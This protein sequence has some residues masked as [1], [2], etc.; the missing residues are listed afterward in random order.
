MKRVTA[1]L[2]SSISQV[3]EVITVEHGASMVGLNVVHFEPVCTKLCE[4]CEA[5]K[6]RVRSRSNMMSY[7]EMHP[8]KE[9]HK[10]MERAVRKKVKKARRR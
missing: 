5:L 10:I 2:Y 3:A 1:V 6:R 8:K 4:W 7:E 9:T